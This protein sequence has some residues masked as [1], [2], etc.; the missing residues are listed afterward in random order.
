MDNVP[1]GSNNPNP[2]LHAWG[3]QRQPAA[4]STAMATSTTTKKGMTPHVCQAIEA[5][6]EER[7][8]IGRAFGV[9]R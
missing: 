8:A 7:V 3:G 6:D 4:S 2:T 1:P 9:E 5:I